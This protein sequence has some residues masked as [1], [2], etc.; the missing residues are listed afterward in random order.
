MKRACDSPGGQGR[1]DSRT[2]RG[3]RSWRGSPGSWGG[4]RRGRSRGRGGMKEGRTR[5]ET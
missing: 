4:R 1:M 3:R 2:V 5:A